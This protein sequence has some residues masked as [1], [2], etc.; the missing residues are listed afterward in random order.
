MINSIARTVAIVALSFVA[1]VFILVLL[2]PKLF[3]W[4]AFVVTSGSMAPAFQAGSVVVV[5]P[6]PGE[7]VGMR[8]I[9][10]FR[11]PV[12][13]TTHRIV[14]IEATSQGGE[15]DITFTTKGDANEEADPVPLDPRNIV[16]KANFAVPHVGYVIDLVRSP[17][18]AGV[19]AAL[20]LY[21]TFGGRAIK[22][23]RNDPTS[24]SVARDTVQVG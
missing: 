12:G 19:L 18:G 15:D 6:I 2:V 22:P 17:V 21:A 14:G 5:A 11:D 24:R 23:D 7:Q 10:T 3:G 16:G 13:Y 8:D 9:V 20:I 1:A 4:D